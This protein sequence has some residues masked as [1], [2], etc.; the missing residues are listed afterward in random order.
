MKYHRHTS[1][2]ILRDS[3]PA[4]FLSEND[5]LTDMELKAIQ[6][7]T[8]KSETP[9]WV[10]TQNRNIPVRSGHHLLNALRFSD[11][12]LQLRILA[13]TTLSD[14]SACVEENK[15]LIDTSLTKT[16]VLEGR[17]SFILRLLIAHN[18]EECKDTIIKI[19]KS[20][21]PVAYNTSKNH[22]RFGVEFVNSN[23]TVAQGYNYIGL[24]YTEE[25]RLFAEDPVKYLSVPPIEATLLGSPIRT[26]QRLLSRD[27]KSAKPNN[28]NL[29]SLV[30]RSATKSR[31]EKFLED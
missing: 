4:H 22:K 17:L 21:L 10:C 3:V 26:Y 25:F 12:G 13:C 18:Y 9:F 1:N 5:D 8:L 11:A 31:L 2:P 28:A 16:L 6:C 24:L 27:D 19:A 15:N 23:D 30:A 7:L 29:L 20:R 14:V